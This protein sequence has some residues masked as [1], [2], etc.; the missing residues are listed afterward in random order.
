M[1][2]LKSSISATAEPQFTDVWLLSTD[3]LRSRSGVK[4]S[5][6]RVLVWKPR[7]AALLSTS[8]SD[9]PSGMAGSD[10]RR[11]AA[12]QSSSRLSLPHRLINL[13][14]EPHKRRASAP[15]YQTCRYPHRTPGRA[16]NFQT[17]FQSTRDLLA[18]VFKAAG[19]PALDFLPHS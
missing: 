16:E 9:Y 3:R 17:F 2:G 13:S 11:T 10:T 12:H 1:S 15:G 8:A 19:E 14:W 6:G 4:A 7:A 18:C 5:E